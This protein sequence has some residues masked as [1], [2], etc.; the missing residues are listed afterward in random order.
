MR[1][2]PSPVSPANLMHPAQDQHISPL[3]SEVMASIAARVNQVAHVYQA[4]KQRGNNGGVGPPNVVDHLM[5]KELQ[6]MQQGMA[7]LGVGG[8]GGGGIVPHQNMQA[9]SGA[10]GSS[11]LP[12]NLSGGKWN[13][14]C[15][16]FF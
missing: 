15:F 13:S 1:M 2:G 11:V 10:G 14:F 5:D 7:G 12:M 8:G 16:Y 6:F 3:T 4:A 9:M